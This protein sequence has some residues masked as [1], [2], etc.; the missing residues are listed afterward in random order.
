[1][2]SQLPGGLVWRFQPAIAVSWPGCLMKLPELNALMWFFNH[3]CP[4]ILVVLLDAILPPANP[5]W[6][7][8]FLR[9]AGG[10]EMFFRWVSA[11]LFA[12]G[13]VCY[14]FVMNSVLSSWLWACLSLLLSFCSPLCLKSMH[15]ATKCRKMTNLWRQCLRG[16]WS[17]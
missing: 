11:S 3:G 15:G 2:N 14:M 17:R 7:A 6:Y 4:V 10:V 5:S 13:A 8:F 16:H 1:M 9:F 12:S